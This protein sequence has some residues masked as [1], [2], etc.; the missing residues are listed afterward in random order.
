MVHTETEASPH[1]IVREGYARYRHRT[2]RWKMSLP[3]R[4]VE[5]PDLCIIIDGHWF[6]LVEAI[7]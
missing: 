7:D 4:D 1:A 3:V 5:H 6:D 2:Q